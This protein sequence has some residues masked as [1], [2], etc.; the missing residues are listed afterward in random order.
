MPA[1]LNTIARHVIGETH[2]RSAET[3]PSNLVIV[4]GAS[5]YE[6]QAR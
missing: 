1:E 5:L 2:L 6:I 3:K 4:L